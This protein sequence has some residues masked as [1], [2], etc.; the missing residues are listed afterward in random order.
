M[1]EQMIAARLWH[2]GH[3]CPFSPLV[4]FSAERIAL[5]VQS[6]QLA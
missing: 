3:A 1:Y 5:N 4:D 6:P 2:S